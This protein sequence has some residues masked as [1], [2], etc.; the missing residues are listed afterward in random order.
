MPPPVSTFTTITTS[1]PPPF[2]SSVDSFAF[3][4]TVL[5]LLG[6]GLLAGIGLAA[7]LDC[8]THRLERRKRALA[9]EVLITGATTS[10][11]TLGALVSS[12]ATAPTGSNVPFSLASTLNKR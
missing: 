11:S 3:W 7:L 2:T 9:R 10:P 6:L 8:A 5:L 12:S 4:L 1:S